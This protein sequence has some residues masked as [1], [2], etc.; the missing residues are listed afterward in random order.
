MCLNVKIVRRVEPGDRIFAKTA[1]PNQT[2]KINMVEPGD[3]IFAKTA[4]PNQ[5]FKINAVKKSLL[6]NVPYL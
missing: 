2:Y 6:L 5:T 4:H 1:Q 3:R